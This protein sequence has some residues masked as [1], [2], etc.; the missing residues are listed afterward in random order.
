MPPFILHKLVV[1]SR[2]ALLLPLALWVGG[3]VALF[4]LTPVLF[5][6]LERAQAG[7]VAG[8]VLRRADALFLACILLEVV[9]LAFRSY[10]DRAAPPAALVVPLGAMMASRLVSSLAVAPAARALRTR[11]RDAN[12]PATD[13]ERTAFGRLHALST[14]LLAVEVMLGT[15]ALFALS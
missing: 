6:R 12:A 4:L 2:F 3:G 9:G 8:A 13:A 11:M 10:V 15:Y 5:K 1:V 7:E 14:V